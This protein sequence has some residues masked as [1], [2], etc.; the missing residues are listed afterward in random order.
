MVH[1]E[2]KNWRLRVWWINDG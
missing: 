1:E 2:T